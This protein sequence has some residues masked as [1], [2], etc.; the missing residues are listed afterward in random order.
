MSINVTFILQC[1]WGGGRILGRSAERLL[2]D[3][4]VR[5]V[6]AI[7]EA[8]SCLSLP[9][10]VSHGLL[11]RVPAEPYHPSS[12]SPHTHYVTVEMLRNEIPFQRE[13][14]ITRDG[15]QVPQPLFLFPLAKNG[16]VGGHFA[17]CL[18]GHTH[19]CKQSS[20]S[21]HTHASRAHLA[22]TCTQAELWSRPEE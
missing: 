14:L 19:A 10:S 1:V 21:T 7:K 6:R 13:S 8:Y 16:Y 11:A 9:F 22:H 4:G 17:R 2:L 15:T 18:I 3:E 20:F 5:G 12:Q